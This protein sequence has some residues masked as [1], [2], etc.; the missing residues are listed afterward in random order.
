M[1]DFYE[2]TFE[3]KPTTYKTPLDKGDHPEVDETELASESDTA[4]YLSLIGQL[5]WLVALGRFDIFS[6]VTTMSRFRTAPR[7]G[8]LE[9]LKRMYGYVWDTRKFAIRI[10]TGEPDYSMFPDQHFDWSYSVYG[11]SVGISS[12]TSP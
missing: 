8:H 2:R 10:R 11:V 7:K 4:I 3:K 1:M 6:A 5:Q 9:R 12:V